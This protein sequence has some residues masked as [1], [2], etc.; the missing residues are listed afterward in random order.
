[1]F[2]QALI[3]G[4]TR[5]FGYESKITF[6]HQ[7]RSL[8]DLPTAVEASA[9]TISLLSRLVTFGTFLFI[10]LLQGMRIWFYTPLIL[11]VSVNNVVAQA[12]RSSK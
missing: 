3:S 4:N 8:R 10:I 1:M 12:K 9:V 6:D 11:L 7:Y 5:Q 2:R